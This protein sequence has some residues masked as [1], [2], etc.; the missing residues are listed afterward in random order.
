MYT[1]Q[2]YVILGVAPDA[3]M[4][5]I[6]AAYIQAARTHHP[7]K[8]GHLSPEDRA[9]HEG[10]FKTITDAYSRIVDERAARA[11]SARASFSNLWRAP[12][13]QEEW[14]VVWEGVERMFSRV[15]VME[16][17]KDLLSKAAELARW[18]KAATECSE[19]KPHIHHAT[20][21]VSPADVQFG[22]QRRVR[23]LLSDEREIFV[24]VDCGVFPEPFTQEKER[25]ERICVCVKLVLDSTET[26]E[27]EPGIWDLYRT[28]DVPLCEW[29]TGS[30]YALEP[31]A[32][33][34]L[35]QGADGEHTCVVEPCRDPLRPLQL[36]VPEFWK[37]GLV[38]VSINIKWPLLS[39]WER[40][41]PESRKNILDGLRTLTEHSTD[42]H[43]TI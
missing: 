21:V 6:R 27:M 41:N 35:G 31:L 3:P 23:V 14:E 39:S 13:T 40:V 7:D 24:N 30:R 28:I 26:A 11:D 10:I 17:V 38:I 36:N 29:F 4:E 18:R 33:Q 9:K 22:R 37:F 32:S 2:H 42:E 43:K 15:E 19:R 12:S 16:S 20:L 8:L 25:D 5:T 34:G 1:P